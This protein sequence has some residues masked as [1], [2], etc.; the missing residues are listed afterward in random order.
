MLT[1]TIVSKVEMMMSRVEVEVEYIAPY[2]PTST[3]N[4][5]RRYFYQNGN[6]FN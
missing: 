5:G 2:T 1:I 3:T 6:R 4:T